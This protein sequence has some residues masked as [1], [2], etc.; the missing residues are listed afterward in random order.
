MLRSA[1]GD[2]L[3]FSNPERSEGSLFHSGTTEQLPVN[4]Q[5]CFLAMG[6]GIHDFRAAIDAIA[7]GKVLFS[8]PERSEGSLFRSGT[9]AFR[10]HC[11]QEPLRSGTT[12]FRNH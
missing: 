9:T 5:R 7:T 3:A 10:N 6:N 11:V 8:N 2:S 12:A 4:S 1:M